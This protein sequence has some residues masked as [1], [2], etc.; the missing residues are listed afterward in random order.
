MSDAEASN[1]R[2]SI[3]IKGVVNSEPFRR[4]GTDQKNQTLASSVVGESAATQHP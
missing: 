2:F 4:Q 1:Y 3:L